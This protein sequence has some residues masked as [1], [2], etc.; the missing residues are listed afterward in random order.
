MKVL[1]SEQAG[2]PIRRVTNF[3]EPRKEDFCGRSDCYVCLTA[4]KPTRG[5]CHQEGV[6][7]TITCNLC[8]MGGLK[9]TYWGES[10]YSGYYRIKNHM[11]ALRRNSVDSVLMKHQEKFH[12]GTRME[13]G[14][15]RVDISG[16]YPRPILRQCQEGV[17]LA[18]AL[19]IKNQGGP[20]EI[21]NSKM[22][23]LQPG[24]VSRQFKALLS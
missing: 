18:K 16:K 24:V 20:V 9:A 15:F 23:F 19:E 1:V 13:P 6:G 2:D 22:E 10:G 11:N 7:Y 17:A 4:D 8:L 5:K 12:P 21:L 3:T 14:D